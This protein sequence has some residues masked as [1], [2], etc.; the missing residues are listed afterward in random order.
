MDVPEQGK[1]G[2]SAGE[3]EE[4]DQELP[5]SQVMSGGLPQYGSNVPPTGAF[6]RRGLDE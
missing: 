2:G 1:V 4:D 3:Q 6:V 5:R